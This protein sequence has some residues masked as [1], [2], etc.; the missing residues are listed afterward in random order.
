M[1]DKSL[2]QVALDLRSSMEKI[3]PDGVGVTINTCEE[4]DRRGSLSLTV[5]SWPADMVMNNKERVA[6]IRRSLTLNG[7]FLSPD[8]SKRYPRLSAEAMHL[9]ATLQSLVDEHCPA[10]LDPETGH[11]SWKISGIVS[12]DPNALARENIEIAQSLKN[13]G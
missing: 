5:S 10:T 8:D 7:K 6:A 4:V 1:T 12:L 13:Q 3:L 11:T 9:L 2:H